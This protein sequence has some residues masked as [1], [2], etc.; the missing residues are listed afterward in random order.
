[1]RYALFV[2]AMWTVFAPGGGASRLRQAPAS[3]TIVVVDKADGAV[4]FIDVASLTRTGMAS[5]GYL[6]HEIA[7]TPDGQFAYVTNYGREYV[8]S[9]SP[10]N[11]PGNTL[12]VIDLRQKKEV[13][14]IVLGQPP[15]EPH[16]IVTSANGQ[17]I[18]VK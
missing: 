3:A 6:A 13:A 7:S 9:K 1:M 4:S 15:C 12:S 2:G 17:R 10:A 5:A 8:T 11:K 16:G 14:Q 18:Y